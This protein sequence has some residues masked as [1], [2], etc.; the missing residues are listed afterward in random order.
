MRGAYPELIETQSFVAKVVR[1][2]EERFSETL[3][4][5][6]KILREEL[7]RLKKGGEK[8]LSGEVVFRLYDTFGFPPD[9]TAE[10]LQEEGL[11]YD[12]AGF[13][14]QMEEQ[15]QKSKQSWQGIGEGKAKEVYRFR[16]I[17]RNSVGI[18]D[19]ET[20]EG[21]RDGLFC[22]GGGGD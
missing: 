22:Q 4:S 16:G 14:T 19:P 5:G 7:E 3:D 8:T 18:E 12:E 17:R 21:R 6:L 2:E 10:I 13:Q 1:N 20:D 15:R 9:L 11:G